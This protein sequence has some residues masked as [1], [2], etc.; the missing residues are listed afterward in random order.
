MH[1]RV[2]LF[3]PLPFGSRP[4]PLL[5]FLSILQVLLPPRIAYTLLTLPFHSGRSSLCLSLSF[6]PFAFLPQYHSPYW[7]LPEP[8]HP[9]TRPASSSNLILA[10]QMRDFDDSKHSN[11]FELVAIDDDNLGGTS[12]QQSPQPPLSSTTEK[13]G[14][15]SSIY[16]SPRGRLFALA[17][18]LLVNPLVQLI[19]PPLRCLQHHRR[20]QFDLIIPDHLAVTPCS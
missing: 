12:S 5:S 3:D 11:S 17:S 8:N 2:V 9:S 20:L 18:Y 10:M 19:P 16:L 6:Y 1:F 14:C 13:P 4:P 15:W 7:C